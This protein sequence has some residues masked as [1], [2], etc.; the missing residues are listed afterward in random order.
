MNTPVV[1]YFSITGH[2]EKLARAIAKALELPVQQI[3]DPVPA[4]DLL[5]IVNEV[6][7]GQTNPQVIEAIEKLDA[8]SI[9]RAVIVTSSAGEPDDLQLVRKALEDKA[10][11]VL[12]KEFT[13]QDTVSCFETGEPGWKE[14]DDAVAFSLMARTMSIY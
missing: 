6:H 10:I 12:D 7:R 4:T 8:E 1:A 13:C 9:G 11:P 3:T 5:Y 2:A 14:I